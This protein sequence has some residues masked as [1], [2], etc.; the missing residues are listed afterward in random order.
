M[1]PTPE[2]VKNIALEIQGIIDEA[3]SDYTSK[4]ERVIRAE[5]QIL[6]SVRATTTK[7]RREDVVD[8]VCKELLTCGQ[9]NTT[10]DLNSG[11][12]IPLCLRYTVAL[13]IASR[14]EYLQ[15]KGFTCNLL[16]FYNSYLK[17]AV[18]RAWEIAT[19]PYS[20]ECYIGRICTRQGAL[21]LGFSGKAYRQKVRI[22]ANFSF[23]T[24]DSMRQQLSEFASFLSVTNLNDVDEGVTSTKRVTPNTERVLEFLNK[25]KAASC[26]SN[27]KPKPIQKKSPCNISPSQTFVKTNHPLQNST[28]N[29]VGIIPEASCSQVF[30]CE[31]DV[32]GLLDVFVRKYGKAKFGT[33]ISEL[34]EMLTSLTFGNQDEVYMTDSDWVAFWNSPLVS[35]NFLSILKR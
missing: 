16:E 34:G 19:E 15:Y 9:K 3:E 1:D 33:S 13:R 17:Q 30:E 21:L 20:E 6:S 7:F 5:Q 24:F 10:L 14:K 8:D 25:K 4:Y 35:A 22:P 26:S 18:D 32:H 11:D 12:L 2:D 31:T 23:Y 29:S 27:P 28:T